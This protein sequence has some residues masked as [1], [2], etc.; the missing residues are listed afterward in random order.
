MKGKQKEENVIISIKGTQHYENAEP[1]LVELVTLGSLKRDEDGV[2][3]TYEE[4]ELTG[5]EGTTTK[6]RIEDEGPRVTLLR[7]GSVNTQMIF[8]LGQRYLSLYE[9]PY[10]SMSVGIDTRRLKNTVG[11]TGGDLE[12]DYD[13]E[14][15][16]L[17]AGKNLFRLNVRRDPAAPRQ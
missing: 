17:L 13:I 15:N 2:T 16:N 6:V 12:I 4:S 5:M 3:I 10:G 1:G 9:T 11:E 8:Q 14:F 7:E